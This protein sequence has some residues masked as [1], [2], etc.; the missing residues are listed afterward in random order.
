VLDLIL[1]PP[2]GP[3]ESF[4]LL[5]PASGAPAGTASLA[6]RDLDSR[7]DLTPWLAGVYVP[8]R[9]RGRGH[10]TARVRH[11]ERFAA[12][13]GVARLWLYTNTAEPLYARLGWRRAGTERTRRR[14]VEVALMCRDLPGEEGEG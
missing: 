4:V 11:V 10:A 14:G 12:A 5:D 8:P 1:A 6:H 9:F 13:A 3:E 7:P 2:A